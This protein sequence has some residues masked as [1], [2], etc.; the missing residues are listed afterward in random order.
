MTFSKNVLP[1]QRGVHSGVNRIIDSVGFSDSWE[2]LGG[3]EGILGV[4]GGSLW[5]LVIS[6]NSCSGFSS[7]DTSAYQTIA[8]SQKSRSRHSAVDIWAYR[9]FGVKTKT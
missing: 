4:W 6:I 7:V 8:I 5:D 3:L 9:L 1:P 2:A